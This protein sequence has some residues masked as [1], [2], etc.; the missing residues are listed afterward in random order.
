MYEIP[1]SEALGQLIG[2]WYCPN[3]QNGGGAMVQLSTQGGKFICMFL[4]RCGPDESWGYVAHRPMDAAT[5]DR[6]IAVI[7]E[8]N[9]ERQ[10]QIHEILTDDFDTSDAMQ[11]KLQSL[12][13]TN[14]RFL[15]YQ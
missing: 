10:E 9:S 13:C 12:G 15:T 3:I 2:I 14:L 11:T 4:F 1:K 6:A 7:R 8:G 5:K